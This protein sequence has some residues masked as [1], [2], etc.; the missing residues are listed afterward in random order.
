MITRT[1]VSIPTGWRCPVCSR[2]YA[3]AIATCS[4]CAP[5]ASGA[6]VPDVAETMERSADVQAACDR[7]DEK[8]KAP[9]ADSLAD[10]RRRYDELRLKYVLLAR[11]KQDAALQ[12]YIRRLDASLVQ[13]C[14]L[15]ERLEHWGR[16]TSCSVG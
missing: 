12:P 7:T 16:S 4:A 14:L 3:P 5:R 8:A 6:D 11:E 10:L 2:V 9:P 13:L 15:N 1:S